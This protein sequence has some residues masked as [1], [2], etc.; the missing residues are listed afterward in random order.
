MIKEMTTLL[1]YFRQIHFGCN[2]KFFKIFMV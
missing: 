1:D 2:H